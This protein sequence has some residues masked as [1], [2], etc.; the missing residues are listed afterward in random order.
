MIKFILDWAYPICIAQEYLLS[1]NEELANHLVALL[2]IKEIPT[3]L[4]P[5]KI[6]PLA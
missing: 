6:T 3:D 5:K 1:I 2:V 4:P